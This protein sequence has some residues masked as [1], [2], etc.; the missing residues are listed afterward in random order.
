MFEH[1][2]TAV[3]QTVREVYEMVAELGAK[4]T[5]LEGQTTDA[6][7]V[8]LLKDAFEEMQLSS[9]DALANLYVHFYRKNI[10]PTYNPE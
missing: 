10:D 4:L 9:M 3:E 1:L 6:G 7:T 8:G 2:E 5:V